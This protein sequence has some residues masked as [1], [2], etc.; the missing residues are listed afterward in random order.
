[1]VRPIVLKAIL[2]VVGDDI[3]EACGFLQKCSGC[4]AGLEAAVHAMQQIY[5]DESTE[6]ILSVDA[7]THSSV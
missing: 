5:E 3:E 1:M 7:K 4:P 2:R 6:G